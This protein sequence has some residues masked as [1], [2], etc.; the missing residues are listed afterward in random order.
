M[1]AVEITDVLEAE[2]VLR[3]IADAR[4]NHLIASSERGAKGEYADVCARILGRVEARFVDAMIPEPVDLRRE[5][6]IA[7]IELGIF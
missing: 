7:E 2:V 6:A 1:K 3:A 5:D 4:L